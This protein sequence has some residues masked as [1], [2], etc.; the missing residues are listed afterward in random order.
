MMEKF[1]FLSLIKLSVFWIGLFMFFWKPETD[2]DQILQAI[3]VIFGLYIVPASLAM[4]LLTSRRNV[5]FFFR[6]FFVKKTKR[7]QQ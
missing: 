2:S 5:P 6:P 1:N 4:E 7:W 3:F